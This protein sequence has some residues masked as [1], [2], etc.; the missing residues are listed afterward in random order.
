PKPVH[1]LLVGLRTSAEEAL[2]EGIVEEGIAVADLANLRD[3]DPDHRG[4][5]LLNST[6]DRVLARYGD[7]LAEL[8]AADRRGGHTPALGSRCA[9]CAVR[10]RLAR[11]KHRCKEQCRKNGTDD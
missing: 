9:A 4:R 7:V 11:G 2:E 8:R 10:L 3:V 5:H 1:L 6:G